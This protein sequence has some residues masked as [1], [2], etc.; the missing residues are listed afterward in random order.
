MNDTEYLLAFWNWIPHDW[1]EYYTK[2]ILEQMA[3][4]LKSRGYMPHMAALEAM[5]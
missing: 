5:K 4:T 1:E 2:E 3:L